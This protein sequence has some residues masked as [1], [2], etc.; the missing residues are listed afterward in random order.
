MRNLATTT[1]ELK[2]STHYHGLNANL[3]ITNPQSPCRGLGVE[4][5][6]ELNSHLTITNSMRHHREFEPTYELTEWP[7]CNQ[8]DESSKHYELNESRNFHQLN[9]SFHY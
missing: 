4:R 8:L 1:H 9:L 5:T 2:E 3:A 6:Y 7:E